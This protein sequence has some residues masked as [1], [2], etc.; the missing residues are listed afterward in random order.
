[1]VQA[2]AAGD[3]YRDCGDWVKPKTQPH[4]QTNRFRNTVFA[5]FS[6]FLFSCGA[7]K[8]PER[9]TVIAP[10]DFAG[11][12]KITTCDMDAK[13]DYIL[14]DASG[15]GSTSVCAATPD[16]TFRVVRGSSTV[17]VPATASKTGD[18]IVVSLTA[19]VGPRDTAK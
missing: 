7:K 11:K 1:V 5:L 8:A 18:D 12:I 10:E 2:I 6:L 14:L 15:K 9:L 19:T 3:P 17:E 4:M 16:F 13:S